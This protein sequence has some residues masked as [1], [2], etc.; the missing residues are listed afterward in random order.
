MS[1]PGPSSP[2]QSLLLFPPCQHAGNGLQPR[3]LQQGL[4]PSVDSPPA[5]PGAVATKSIQ[6]VV[7]VSLKKHQWTLRWANFS[8]FQ[9]FKTGDAPW[10]NL[11]SVR[12]KKNSCALCVWKIGRTTHHQVKEALTQHRYFIGWHKQTI[13]L[14]WTLLKINMF[15]FHP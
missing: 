8:T 1:Y 3:T 6:S 15:F 5:Q 7:K 2:A 10:F 11:N 14:G 13:Q 4:Q 12:F 9:K